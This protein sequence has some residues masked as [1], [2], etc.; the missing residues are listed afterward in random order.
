MLLSLNRLDAAEDEGWGSKQHER[1]RKILGM[2]DDNQEPK[3]TEIC[4]LKKNSQYYALKESAKSVVNF[5]NGGSQE[6]CKFMLDDQSEQPGILEIV[7][8]V[9]KQ[10]GTSTFKDTYYKIEPKKPKK[11][12]G[13][14]FNVFKRKKSK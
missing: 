2:V 5:Y 10:I 1:L 3:L 4:F 6:V 13:S 9:D 14:V 12:I 7:A 8:F 11:K